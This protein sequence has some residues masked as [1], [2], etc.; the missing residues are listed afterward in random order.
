MDDETRVILIG[1]TSNVG[2]STLGHALA[3]RLGWK[4]M[5]TDQLA[6]HPGRPWKT[7]ARDI[8]QHVVDHYLT[9]T[10]DELIADVL[11][12]Y[13]TVWPTIE[14]L[15]RKHADLSEDRLILEGSAILP[16]RAAALG[17]DN[18]ARFWLTAPRDLLEAR[19]R[20][21][22]RADGGSR[23][24][25]KLVEKFLDRTH[26]FDAFVRDEIE[27]LHLDC[28]DVSD[29]PS[30]DVLVEQAPASLRSL[31]GSRS[32]GRRPGRPPRP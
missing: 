3:E 6:R 19:I 10:V 12:H 4:C 11:R 20:A 26:R 27:R 16:E 13:E 32:S 21:E 5:S 17:L 31:P 7:E 15:V 8:P 28:I 29:A 25:K 1:G 24:E 9:L 18:V 23:I 14:A 30:V 2:K 22:S